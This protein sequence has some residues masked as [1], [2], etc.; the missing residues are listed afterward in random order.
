[1]RGVFAMSIIRNVKEL[2]TA[3]ALPL[4]IAYLGAPGSFSAEAAELHAAREERVAELHGSPEVSGVL[5]LLTAR[6]CDRAVL[7][8]ANTSSGLVWTALQALG[9]HALE[10]VDEIVM[11]V[12]FSLFAARSD[13]ELAAI[14]RVASHP[15]ALRQC[16][17]HLARLL[18]GRIHLPWSDTAS[19]AR[20][21]SRGVLAPSTAVLASARAGV[22]YGLAVLERDVHDRPD[23]R[24]FFAVLRRTAGTAL[25]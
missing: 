25:E 13:V 8:V 22:H 7:P 17:R 20:D 10:L 19:A 5:A 3:D 1:M 14:E 4:R 18:P 11:P 23:N 15:Q 16:D 12:R 2:P 6:V 21:L 9:A 24:T